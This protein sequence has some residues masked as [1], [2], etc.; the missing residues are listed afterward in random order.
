[1]SNQQYRIRVLRPRKICGRNI[2]ASTKRTSVPV[3]K[4]QMKRQERR[5]STKWMGIWDAVSLGQQLDGELNAAPNPAAEDDTLLG[6]VLAGETL[7]KGN[8]L[9]HA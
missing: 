7:I 9:I 5:L 2:I 3:S 6:E 4:Y 1:M 8:H